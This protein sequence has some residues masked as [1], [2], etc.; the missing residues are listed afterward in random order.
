MTTKERELALFQPYATAQDFLS[1]QEMD[2]LIAEH[3]P[4][5][6]EGTLSYGNADANLRRS[7][8]VQLSRSEDYDGGD[9]ELR[10]GNVPK[11]FDRARGALII[12]PT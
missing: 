12:F 5:V 6:A 8:V 10:Y 11:K 1:A 4:R 7:R 2:R 9:L 3:G